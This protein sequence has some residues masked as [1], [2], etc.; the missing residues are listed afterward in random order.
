MDA[1][2][3]AAAILA[4]VIGL[5]AFVAVARAFPRLT[6]IERLVVAWW[7]AIAVVAFSAI[8]LGQAREF[9]IPLAGA[10]MIGLGVL[11]VVNYGGVADRLAARRMGIGPFWHQQSPASWRLFAGFLV[12]I[13]F[14]WIFGSLLT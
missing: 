4:V 8:P 2:G 13:G 11:G 5:A 9:L 14:F 3:V 12:V 7:I 6:F 10:M 1:F